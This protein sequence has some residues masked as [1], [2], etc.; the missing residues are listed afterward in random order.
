MAQLLLQKETLEE[1]DIAALRAQIERQVPLETIPSTC[2][3]RAAPRP[4]ACDHIRLAGSLLVHKPRSI[5]LA[6]L[7]AATSL[8]RSIKGLRD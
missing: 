1:Q 2:A 4:A 5:R 7:R 8:G 6:E 3:T